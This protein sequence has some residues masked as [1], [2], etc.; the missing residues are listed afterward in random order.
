[1]GLVLCG[2]ACCDNMVPVVGLQFVPPVGV[3]TVGVRQGWLLMTG[4][5]TKIAANWGFGLFWSGLTD[6]WEPFVQ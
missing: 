1:M 3:A 2:S 5:G 4:T 6:E